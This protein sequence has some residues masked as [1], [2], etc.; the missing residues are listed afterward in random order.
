MSAGQKKRMH[1]VPRS[2]LEAFAVVDP[3]RR[4]PGI[5]RFDRNGAFKVVGLDQAEVV[6]HFYTVFRDG[7]PDTGIEDILCGIEGDFCPARDAIV[8]RQPLEKVH[9]TAL[10]RFIAAQL[11][12]TP[13]FFQ[14][15]CAFLD[16]QGVRYEHNDLRG[17]M[18][19]LIDY[20][21]PRLARMNAV[22]AYNDTS[23]PFL[24][25]DNPAVAWKKSPDGLVWG[26]LDQY[27]PHLI[28]S[29]PLTPTLAFVAYQTPTSL[30]AANT[31]DHETPRHER[32]AKTFTTHVDCGTLPEAEVQRLNG[33]CIAN[34][35]TCVYSCYNDTA[36]EQ[37]INTAFG[38]HS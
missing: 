35:H 4:S 25:S 10:A 16:F 11:L 29:C 34:A 3:T 23:V 38:R 15:M 36:L 24:T 18:L 28:I 32:V 6:K 5:W 12:R 1:T 20:W 17:A 30:Q 26:V 27:D 22:Y 19:Q 21:I 2:Y 37:H 31:E 14:S 7:S 9:R 33:L 8:E 13:R